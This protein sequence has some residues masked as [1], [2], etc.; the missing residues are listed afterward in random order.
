M[1]NRCLKNIRV[2]FSIILLALFL[3]ACGSSSSGSRNVNPGDNGEVDCT[4]TESPEVTCDD[5]IDNDCDGFIDGDD[6]DCQPQ[7]VAVGDSGTVL[8]SGDKD[9][10]VVGRQ[11]NPDQNILDV[12]QG[13]WVAVGIETPN[14]I[15]AS[16]DDVGQVITEHPV[17]L[18]AFTG[19]ANDGSGTW[20]AVGAVTVMST[21]G[22]TSKSDDDGV[23]WVDNVNSPLDST[24]SLNEVAY[25]NGKW[26]AVGLGGKIFFSD[27]GESWQT[28]TSNTTTDLW[29]VA[30]GGNDQWVAVGS[31]PDSQD[32]VIV[33]TTTANLDEWEFASYQGISAK[34]ILNDVA[35]GESGRFVAVGLKGIIYFSDN[36][37][38]WQ[39]SKGN[40]EGN[41]LFGVVYDGSDW[42]AVGA[43]R[44]TLNGII[45]HTDNGDIDVWE[46]S[47]N[48]PDVATLNSIA[49][50][51]P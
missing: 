14:G 5:G 35:S 15:V 10:W 34:E 22:I 8:L 39:E 18:A 28:A 11:T 4:S 12:A 44:Q 24:V 32:A 41:N 49:V 47:S 19:V 37:S 3:T 26:V 50:K 38:E 2:L 9:N 40:V 1:N 30:Y 45:F 42:V 7:Y 48:I 33:H 13:S 6:P 16:V 23:N 31:A 29:G 17:S 43:D 20:I 36:G 46:R 27:D 21:Q 51:V 25:G